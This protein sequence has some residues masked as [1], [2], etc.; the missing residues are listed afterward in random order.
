MSKPSFFSSSKPVAKIQQK[1]LDNEPSLIISFLKNVFSKFPLPE[2]TEPATFNRTEFDLIFL[3]L[4]LSYQIYLEPENRNYPSEAGK[5]ISRNVNATVKNI[6]YDILKSHQSNTLFIVC[7]G[8]N[9]INDFITDAIA[10]PIQVGEDFYHKGMY[11][12]T[13]NLLSKISS[14]VLHHQKIIFTGH[15][16]GS[17]CASI[18]VHLL[19]LKNPELDIHAIVFAPPAIVCENIWRRSYSLVKCFV[20][21]DDFIPFLSLHNASLIP[22]H[23]FPKKNSKFFTKIF[24]SNE[25]SDLEVNLID[26]PEKNVALYPLGEAFYLS[27]EYEISKIQSFSYFGHFVNR[28]ADHDHLHPVYLEAFEGFKKKRYETA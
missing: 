2:E 24:H 15:S 19:K 5:L 16:L 8:T 4:Q 3:C 9:C 13:I 21:G 23:L 11:E 18:A 10:T 28:F 26:T 25:K 20:Y 6:S 1:A 7:R 12:A 17:G 27:H 22:T 14:L